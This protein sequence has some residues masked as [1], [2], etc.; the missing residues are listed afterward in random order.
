MTFSYELPSPT[1]DASI[2]PATDDAELTFASLP[3]SQ[4]SVLP[5]SQ[6]Q[7]SEINSECPEATASL[8]ANDDT[9]SG[10][11]CCDSGGIDGDRVPS[12]DG[13]S[14]SNDTIDHSDKDQA[15]WHA[16][17]DFA[18]PVN[19][20]PLSS[21]D[22]LSSRKRRRGKPRTSRSSVKRRTYG[23]YQ[24]TPATAAEQEFP[25][26]P[27]CSPDS[28]MF[29]QSEYNRLNY[30][31]GPFTLDACASAFDTKCPKYGSTDDPFEQKTIKGETIFFNPPYDEKVLPMLENFESQRQEHPYDTKAIM[32]LPAWKHSDLAKTWQPFLSKYKKVHTYPAG[33]YIFH[34]AVDA[35]TTTPMGP[36]EW[37]VDVWLADSS[38]EERECISTEMTK[39]RNMSASK[40]SQPLLTLQKSTSYE[41][42]QY[43]PHQPRYEGEKQYVTVGVQT[44]QISSSF[45]S[46]SSFST[47]HISFQGHF[48]TFQYTFS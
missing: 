45:Q 37:P 35:V 7:R 15:F 47:L 13:Q 21:M 17:A 24:D 42:P 25:R 48:K 11:T 12:S 26:P 30:L 31:Y 29:D 27:G 44:Q 46:S 22:K 2:L 38:V 19:D 14:E 8:P 23:I 20:I 36:T 39:L 43:K 41:K 4:R 1:T 9:K 40:S 33:S 6:R 28:I 32:I 3:E 16:T 34:T 5:E 18:L 10:R